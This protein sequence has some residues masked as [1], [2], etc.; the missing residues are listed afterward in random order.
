MMGKGSTIS[1]P[2]CKMRGTWS[3]L[4]GTL[5]VQARAPA[6]GPAPRKGSISWL[7]MATSREAKDA[8]RND[9]HSIK[10]VGSDPKVGP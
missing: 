5:E 9:P 8:L 1:G 3:V 7:L 2:F 10:G 4:L 6:S